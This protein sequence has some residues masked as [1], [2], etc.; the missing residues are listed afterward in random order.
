MKTIL[1]FAAGL[2][3]TLSTMAADKPPS[4]TI[5]SNR[6]FEVVVDGR[7]YRNDNTIRLDRMRPGMHSIQ[8]Y[9]RSRGFFGR[10]R[11][12][13][14]KNFFVRNNDLR[15][16]VNYSGYV[17]IDERRYDRRDRG[18]DDNDRGRD[19]NDRDYGRN[20]GY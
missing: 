10:M 3:L 19:P 14:S 18:W 2:L 13:S 12:V 8:V 17:N 6:N 16:T 1:T 15:I 4:V 5:K 9:E 20:R 11:L 7:N